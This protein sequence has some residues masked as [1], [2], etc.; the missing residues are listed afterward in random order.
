MGTGGYNHPYPLI[1][2]IVFNFCSFFLFI[3][4]LL[5]LITCL[6][7]TGSFA[8]RTWRGWSKNLFPFALYSSYNYLLTAL[9]PG[10]SLFWTPAPSYET[11]LHCGV[12]LLLHP[13]LLLSFL[14]VA[15]N[16]IIFHLTDQPYRVVI[17]SD[18]AILP[19]H[20]T[21]V[22]TLLTPAG[23]LS[24]NIWGIYTGLFSSTQ[25]PIAGWRYF[26]H[27]RFLLKINFQSSV[28]KLNALK[29][30]DFILMGEPCE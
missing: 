16:T 4:F 13:L 18:S 20:S 6:G 22:L 21:Y 15:T 7:G 28:E 29:L 17:S 25:G 3:A 8:F 27:E 26:S 11:L 14:P 19:S 24:R 30:G 9:Y 1:E 2:F 12:F 5:P 10:C 23:L